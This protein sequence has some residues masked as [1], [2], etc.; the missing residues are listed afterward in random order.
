MKYI[1]SK[2]YNLSQRTKILENKKGNLFIV[3]D[4]KSRI[5]MKDGER[6]VIIVEK[7]KKK[8]KKKKISLL[9]SAPVCRKTKDFLLEKNIKTE[10]MQ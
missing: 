5:V 7:I 9:T 10:V 3:V 6:I 2:K 8:S 4:R 1:D